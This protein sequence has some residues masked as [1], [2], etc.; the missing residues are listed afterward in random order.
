MEY[1]R[2]QEPIWIKKNKDRLNRDE[3]RCRL[4]HIYDD[5][6][7]SQPGRGGREGRAHTRVVHLRKITTVSPSSGIRLKKIV[8]SSRNVTV[9]KVD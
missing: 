6:L 1:K 3:G 5:L 7:K 2:H 9:K 8:D 4:S